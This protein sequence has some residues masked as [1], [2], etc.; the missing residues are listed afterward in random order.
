MRLGPREL[1]RTK[2]PIYRTLKL[3]GARFSPVRPN[4]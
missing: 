4:A 2:E 1:L 3:A